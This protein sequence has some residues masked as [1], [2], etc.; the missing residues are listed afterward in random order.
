MQIEL[1][2][3]LREL[4]ITASFVTHDQDE[5][6]IMSDRIAV[7]NQGVIEQF[8]Q[9]T[10]IYMQPAT[11]FVLD[12]VGT[13]T[14]LNGTVKVNGTGADFSSVQTTAG[15][16]RVNQTLRTG[17]RVTVAVRPE[18]LAL[19]NAPDSSYNTLTLTLRDQVFMGSRLV[20]H[21]ATDSGDRALAEVPPARATE[22]Q[23]GAAV[24]LHWPVNQ[25]LAYPA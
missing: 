16:I 18:N 15:D 5:A 12:F 8:D 22:L 9:P 4:A 3:L 1:R 24:P 25:T 23:P 19:G 10:R 6:L 7:M 14:R 2:H 13:A 17:S 21:F 11:A 20:L